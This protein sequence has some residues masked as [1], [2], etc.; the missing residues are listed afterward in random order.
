MIRVKQVKE[1]T[2]I[3]LGLIGGSIGKALKTRQPLIRVCGVDIS[4]ETVR[5]ALTNGIIDRGNVTLEEGVKNADLIFLATPVAVMPEIARQIVPY[6]KEGAIVTDV[7]SIKENIVNLMQ[8]ILPSS[9]Y[10]IGGHPMAGSEKSGLQ[11]ASELLFENAAY[12]LTPTYGTDYGV[13]DTVRGI[14]ESMGARVL[15][16]APAEHDRKV[17]AISHLPHLV[18]SALMTTVGLQEHKEGGYFTL[19]AGG[20][21]DSTRIAASNSQMWVNILMQNRD[22]LIPLVKEFRRNVRKFEKALE[23]GN[24]RQLVKLLARARRWREE[25]PTGL[26]GILPQLYELTVTVPDKPGM[27]G[28]ISNLLGK[29]GI[30]IID[31]EIQRVREAGEGTIR[32]GFTEETARDRALLSLEKNG[33]IV[34]KTGV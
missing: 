13:I 15:L 24:H 3:G 33:F 23:D 30:N 9:V 12:I 32:L 10:F 11:G 20:F 27:I 17:A 1:I 34:A 16:L 21:R 14:V 25:V 26:K 8:E 22:T 19:A 2:I 7:G 5:E 29:N 4:R 31:I 6:L 18:A 28:E